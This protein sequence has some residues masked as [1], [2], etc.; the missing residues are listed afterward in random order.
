MSSKK[1]LKTSK[2][3]KLNNKASLM[4]VV[5]LLIFKLDV[6]LRWFLEEERLP[7]RLKMTICC[8]E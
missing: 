8:L 4:M 3:F 6:F 5:Q 2:H 1:T 7:Y